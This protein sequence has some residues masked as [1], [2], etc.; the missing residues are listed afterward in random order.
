MHHSPTN[1]LVLFV[2]CL[3][4]QPLNLMKHIRYK[5]FLH[6]FCSLHVSDEMTDNSEFVSLASEIHETNHVSSE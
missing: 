2:A 4:I 3:N 5:R 6:Y 1:E